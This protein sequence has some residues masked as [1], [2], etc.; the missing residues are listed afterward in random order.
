MTKILT[1][2]AS[3]VL[4]MSLGACGGGGSSTSDSSAAKSSAS[5][6]PS[7][8]SAS[9]SASSDDA[10][11]AKAISDSLMASSKAGTSQLT[12]KRKEADCIGTGFVDK[13]GTK[14]L[15]KYGLLTKELR[16]DKS[17][18]SVKM[19]PADAKSAT[20]ALFE[21]TD[22][23]A[24]MQKAVGSSGAIP[25]RLRPCV[26]K[27]LNDENLRALFINVFQRRTVAAQKQ[28]VGPIRA[29]ATKGAAG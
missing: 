7:S 28:L 24:M 14:Q 6:S 25:K 3:A 5:A 13:V 2:A 17:V 15:Q 1:A 10:K 26:N 20:G 9:P 22:V 29:C 18:S 21:C 19:T 23:P 12:L 11:A 27:V 16:L 4:L 8:A